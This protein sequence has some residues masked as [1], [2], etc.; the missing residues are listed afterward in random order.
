MIL[1]PRCCGL[2]NVENVCVTFYSNWLRVSFFG[3]IVFFS[4]CRLNDAKFGS[5]TLKTLI[6]SGMCYDI[7]LSIVVF[8]FRIIFLRFHTILHSAPWLSLNLW[9]NYRAIIFNGVDPCKSKCSMV[10][11]SFVHVSQFYWVF[12][13]FVYSTPFSWSFCYFR[14]IAA[15]QSTVCKN[16]LFG[17]FVSNVFQHR[18]I[19]NVTLFYW[20]NF[21]FE[22]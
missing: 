6:P 21:L 8:I 16:A 11:F 19:L 5:N 12:F 17:R 20:K 9:A 3:F 22:R 15:L 1:E 10:S 2:Q 18:L 13:F 4:H 14:K 7:R